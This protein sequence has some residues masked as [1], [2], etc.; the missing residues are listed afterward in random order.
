MDPTITRTFKSSSMNCE[1]V[2]HRYYAVAN[3]TSGFHNPGLMEEQCQWEE[4]KILLVKYFGS[5]RYH[6]ALL[7]C[8]ETAIQLFPLEANWV[9]DSVGFG[10]G[11]R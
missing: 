11:P 10:N 6:S 4:Q 3:P 8:R 2:V 9:I 5:I 1:S 7:G